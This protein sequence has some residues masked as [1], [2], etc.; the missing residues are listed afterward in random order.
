MFLRLIESFL[1]LELRVR[2]IVPY[3]DLLQVCD[4][5]FTRDRLL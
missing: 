4:Y 2:R 3:C 5:R 1:L